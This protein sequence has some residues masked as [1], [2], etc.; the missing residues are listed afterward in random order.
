MEQS[1]PVD[2]TSTSTTP[3]PFPRRVLLGQVQRGRSTERRRHRCPWDDRDHSSSSDGGIQRRRRRRRRDSH[4]S[5]ST[6]SSTR[7]NIRAGIARDVEDVAAR[8]EDRERIDDLGDLDVVVVVVPPADRRRRGRSVGR[9]VRRRRRDAFSLTAAASFAL[10]LC[11]FYRTTAVVFGVG[12]ST[13]HRRCGAPGGSS[14]PASFVSTSRDSP[15]DAVIAERTLA[16]PPSMTARRRTPSRRGRGTFNNVDTSWSNAVR[17]RSDLNESRF[18]VRKRVRTVL[19]KARKRTG[20]E[21][22][23]DDERSDVE[24]TFVQSELNVMIEAASVGGLGEM[25]FN[26]DDDD[27]EGG[28]AGLGCISGGMMGEIRPDA[29]PD[30]VGGASLTTIALSSYDYEG[31]KDVA[32]L[33]KLEGDTNVSTANNGARLVDDVPASAITDPA[34]KST[35]AGGDDSTPRV[36]CVITNDDVMEKVIPEANAVPKDDASAFPPTPLPPPEP[37]PFV[38]PKLNADQSRRVV[39][40]ERV[41]Y[42]DDMGLAGSGFVVWDV[43]APASVVWDCLLDF[44]SYPQTIPTVREV[45]MYTN[46]HLKEDYRAERPLDFE[47]GTAAICKHGVPSVTRAQFLLSKFRLKVAAVHKYRVHPEGDYMIFTLDPASTNM[48]LKY[49][50]GIW[51]TQSDPDGKEG[52][53]RV[54]LLCELLDCGLCGSEGHAASDNVVEAAD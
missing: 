16:D 21:N 14:H 19:D 17:H 23:T 22:V 13:Y 37:L 15:V 48:V 33:A 20:I 4:S 5:T 25:V 36:E 2:F 50:K 10:F 6:P 46:T 30:Y 40:G 39:N 8:R 9:R 18:G 35:G 53:T 28:G 1:R 31:Y 38:L 7:P 34:V 24:S 45:I 26:D 54:W 49:A 12:A 47:D 52:Y 3:S 42:Q 27:G 51:Y 41:Q 44:K 29:R 11:C 43:R 32:V